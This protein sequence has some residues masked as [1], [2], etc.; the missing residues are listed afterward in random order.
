MSLEQEIEEAEQLLRVA[1]FEGVKNALQTH[2]NKLKRQ[3]A[4]EQQA[5][6]APKEA[7]VLPPPPPSSSSHKPVITGTFIPVENFAWDQGSYGSAKIEVFVDL[8][9][10][11]EVKDKVTVHFGTSSFDLKVMDLH[12]KNYRL[13]KDNLEKDIIPEQCSFVVKKNKLVIKLT[14][15]KGEFNYDHW[16][17][18]TAKKKR[19]EEEAAKSKDPMGGEKLVL[20]PHD[21]TFSSFLIFTGLMDMMKNMYEDGD[22]NMKKV[23]GEAMLKSQ[24]GEK[25][26]PPHPDDRMDNMDF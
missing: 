12:G 19:G 26:S 22:E 13:L 14:K 4:A 21:K 6:E 24:R 16:T 17:G 18:L 15:K 7:A 23:I 25:P 8:D 10:V 20:F 2:L 1:T 5:R 9:G 3:Q 11:G